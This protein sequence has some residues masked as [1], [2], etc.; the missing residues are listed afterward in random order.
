GSVGDTAA[1]LF[2]FDT[3][4]TR[5]PNPQ[6]ASTTAGN[7]LASFLLGLG[8][9]GR[10]DSNVASADQ[11]PYYG[12]FAQNDLRLTS[13]LSLNFGLRY[14]W[15]GAY[16]DRYN[17]LNRGFDLNVDSPIAAQAKANYATSPI[18]EVPVSQFQVK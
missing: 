18:P 13:R 15:E 9:G 8:S 4:F 17:R 11:G 3:G 12:F 14:E 6:V 16:A 2:T 10:V 5:G 1:G 7:G